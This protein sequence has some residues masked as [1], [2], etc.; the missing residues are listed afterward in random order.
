M[1][2]PDL[3]IAVSRWTEIDRES[4]TAT[5]EIDHTPDLDVALDSM[6]ARMQKE[7]RP[8]LPRGI[9]RPESGVRS[10][11]T[12]REIDRTGDSVSFMWAAHT[13]PAFEDLRAV[14]SVGVEKGVL[15]K[16]RDVIARADR[17]ISDRERSDDTA[18][19]DGSPWSNTL[20]KALTDGKSVSSSPWSLDLPSTTEG[21]GGQTSTPHHTEGEGAALLGGVTCG[22]LRKEYERIEGR[23]PPDRSTDQAANTG[24]SGAE[25]TTPPASD[26]DNRQ[27]LADYG[28]GGFADAVADNG[29][30]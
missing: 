6:S 25:D 26:A 19:G 23:A 20:T 1:T 14:A 11:I 9:A 30:N 22:E 2:D 8:P 5:G 18:G 27:A 29:D 3:T 7:G 15:E 10:G 28:F 24:G 13:N 12:L 4:R 21:V 17:I 16:V